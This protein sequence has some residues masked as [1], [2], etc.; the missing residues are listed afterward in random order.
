MALFSKQCIVSIF[1]F[2]VVAT[3]S[4]L[5]AQD[6]MKQLENQR[7]QL[8]KSIEYT[9]VFLVDTRENKFASLDELALLNDQIINLQNSL[10]TTLKKGIQERIPIFHFSFK[11]DEMAPEVEP[12]KEEYA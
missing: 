4:N 6:K 7:I 8:E 9:E 10:I 11:I 12:F 1:F 3:A 2:T 5:F